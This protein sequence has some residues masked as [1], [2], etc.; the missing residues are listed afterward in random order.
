MPTRRRLTLLALVVAVALVPG[1][2][3]ERAGSQPS[4]PGVVTVPTEPPAT[5]PPPR[6]AAT[7]LAAGD[8]GKGWYSFDLGRWHLVALNSNCAEAGGCRAARSATATGSACS[9]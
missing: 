4:D 9:S 6:G 5:T 1:C 8:R 7:V 3:N 2:T